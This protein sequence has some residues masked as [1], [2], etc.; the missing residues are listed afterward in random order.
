[1]PT[2]RFDVRLT[3]RAER[4]IAGYRRWKDRVTRELL[5]L[6]QEPYKGHLLKGNLKGC[7]SLEFSLPD[8]AHRAA[9]IVIEADAVCLVFMV[10][11]H[12]GF[13]ERAARRYASLR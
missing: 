11:A 4:D 9:Y 5:A 1:M 2:D 10:A 6:E 3:R 12:E 13:Y 8:G 7:R